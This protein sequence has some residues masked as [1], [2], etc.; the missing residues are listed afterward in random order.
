MLAGIVPRGRVQASL[1]HES[2]ESGKGVALMEA[3][4]R[5]NA[6]FGRG[7]VCFAAEGF[8]RPWWMRQAKR[9]PLFTTSWSDLPRVR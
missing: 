5:I 4:D 9:S 7:T 8:E 6:R 2:R 3:V 1:F